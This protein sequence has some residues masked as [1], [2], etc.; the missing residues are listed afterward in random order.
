MKSSQV[1]AILHLVN[2]VAHSSS[3]HHFGIN[4]HHSNKK[5]LFELEFTDLGFVKFITWNF[6]LGFCSFHFGY[7]VFWKLQNLCC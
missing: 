3:M 7:I 4:S 5:C 6:H 2:L 1:G